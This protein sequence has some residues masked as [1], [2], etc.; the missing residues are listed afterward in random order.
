M[1]KLFQ[2]KWAIHVISLILA[3]TLYFFVNLEAN[4]EQNE[5][6]VDP[7][8]AYETQS[9]EAVLVYIQIYTQTYVVSCITEV[10]TVA[11]ECIPSSLAPI[12]RLRTFD[13]IV[14]LTAYEEGY[15]TVT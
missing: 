9:L 5:S 14:D 1:D 12:S 4:S 7:G 3:L 15:H 11:L 10:V 8:N 13:V 2:N 6:R